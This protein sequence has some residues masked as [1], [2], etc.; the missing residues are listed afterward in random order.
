MALGEFSGLLGQFLGLP[1][2]LQLTVV[3]FGGLLEADMIVELFRAA[4]PANVA[5]SD[6]RHFA[7]VLLLWLALLPLYLWFLIR[8]LGTSAGR[9]P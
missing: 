3:A 7:V 9:S 5:W 2:V 8:V 1:F 6:R 4:R